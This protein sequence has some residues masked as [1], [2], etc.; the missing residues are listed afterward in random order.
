[1]ISRKSPTSNSASDK[2]F[3]LVELMIALF[4]SI[5]VMSVIIQVFLSSKQNY[6]LQENLGRLQENGR[7]AIDVLIKDI[8]QAGYLGEIQEYWDITETAI[9]AQQ[10]NTLSGECF[11]GLY[12]WVTPMIASGGLTPPHIIGANNTSE[13]LSDNNDFAGCISDDDYQTNTDIVSVHYVGPEAVS[14]ANLVQNQLYLRSNLDDG[15][16]FKCNNAGSCVP[17]DAPDTPGNK[18]TTANYPIYSAA[19]FVRPWQSSV[20]DGVPT[21]V[22]AVLSTDSCISLGPCVITEPI[23]EGVANMQVRYGVD[24][25]DDGFADQ[26][27]DADEIDGFTSLADMQEWHKVRTVR[28]WLLLRTER[29]ETGH[30]DS[31]T[32]VLGDTVVTPDNNYRHA[33]FTTTIALR[34]YLG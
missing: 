9:P 32:Y 6:I 11:S 19:Y 28:I 21:L 29:P 31:K 25:D 34:N 5:T 7:F 8:R 27:L 26:Y 13:D 4:L 1:M 3:G 14:D 16:I 30:H 10:V 20:G 17:G 22:R 33:L 18:K 23:V 2:G 24:T 12:S 15:R